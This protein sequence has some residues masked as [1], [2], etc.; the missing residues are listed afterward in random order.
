MVAAIRARQG[1][2]DD[3]IALFHPRDSTSVNNRDQLA[4]LLARHDRIEELR[5]YAA[6]E[7]HG[8][9]AQRLAELLEERGD[10]EGA[11]AVY[12]RPG[13]SPARQLHGAA[14]LAHLLA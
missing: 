1:R 8:H 2:I 12:R 7:Y 14:Q 9:A 10:V 13:H 6:T 4:D 11:I 3:A 5:T